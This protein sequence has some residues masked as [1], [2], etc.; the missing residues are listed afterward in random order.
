MI[1]FTLQQQNH[2]DTAR[3]CIQKSMTKIQSGEKIGICKNDFEF[4]LFNDLQINIFNIAAM[5]DVIPTTKAA[6]ISPPGSVGKP[7]K[8]CPVKTFLPCQFRLQEPF[9]DIF[10]SKEIE[11]F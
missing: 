5:A 7:A 11:P 6:A 9:A 2:P 3:G 8:T 10:H 1:R 4:R